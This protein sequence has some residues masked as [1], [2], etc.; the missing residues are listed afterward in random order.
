MPSNRPHVVVLG[1]GFGGL[2]AAQALRDVAVDVTVVDRNN[3]HL[4]TPLLYQVATAGLSP[5]HVAQPARA[6]LSKQDNVHVR[7]GDVID[8][9]PERARITLRDGEHLDYDY[10]VLAVG[11]QVSYFGNPQWAR[12]A[13]GLKTMEDAL[14]I[15]KRVLRAAEA[16]EVTRDE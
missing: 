4:F 15:R 13:I 12:R 14:E 9:D 5:A 6:A 2:A 7:M 1:A 10:L 16:A 11:S 3:Y 8:V